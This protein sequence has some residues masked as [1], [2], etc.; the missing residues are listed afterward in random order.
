MPSGT[1]AGRSF[2]CLDQESNL[3]L[4][5]RRVPCDPLHHR[6][7][8]Y[9]DQE[10]NLDQGLR[11]ALCDPLHH[12]DRQT[13]ADDSLCTFVNETTGLW[14]VRGLFPQVL[15]FE[16]DAVLR[17]VKKGLYSKRRYPT[18]LAQYAIRQYCDGRRV[19]SR[20]N[21]HD[22]SSSYC[23]R[24]KH[25]TLERLDKF[26]TGEEAW[27]EIV[28]EDKHSGPA[29]VACV[30]ID[31]ATWLRRLPGRV[32]KIAKVL[33]TGE[34][35]HAV[36]RRFNVSDGRISQI[37]KELFLAWQRFQGEEPALATA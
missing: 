12:R 29:E 13:R 21:I 8:Q 27:Q 31:F 36:A 37:R 32:R 2:K 18:P 20:L 23:Q 30:R 17:L 4:D 22:V 35:T 16:G 7:V 26:D 9:P 14:L 33:A 25:V 1:P 3:D 6:D 10:S 28:I 15:P 34:T 24:Q 11:S 19:G 5:L